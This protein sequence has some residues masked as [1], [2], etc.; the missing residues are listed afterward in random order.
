[1]ALIKCSNCGGD[2]SSNADM[3]VHCGK[4]LKSAEMKMDTKT[5]KSSRNL[6]TGFNIMAWVL[7]G[8]MAVVALIF[9]FI[10]FICLIDEDFEGMMM[11]SIMG[12]SFIVSAVVSFMWVKW[13]AL[14]LKNLYEINKKSSK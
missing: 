12:F 14:V 1:M 6:V 9:F 7:A 5:E 2:I 3:C 8:I 11:G 4:V 13:F 10:G